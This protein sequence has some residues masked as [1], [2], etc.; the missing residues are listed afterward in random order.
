MNQNPQGG[1]A[2]VPAGQ[3]TVV[4]QNQIKPNSYLALSCCV[5]WCCNCL[6]GAIAFGLSMASKSAADDGDLDMARSRGKA[7][8][9]VSIAGII[10][11][12]VV[13]VILVIIYFTVGFALAA[14]LQDQLDQLQYDSDYGN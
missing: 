1:Y 9:W 10:F 8:M 12:V 6:F 13:A 7:A 14:S 4:I 2:Q 5:Y 11:T 3:T